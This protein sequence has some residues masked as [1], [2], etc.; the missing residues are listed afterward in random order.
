MAG[1]ITHC[2]L[3]FS[4][5]RPASFDDGANHSAAIE[6]RRLRPHLV[7][8]R[9]DHRHGDGAHSSAGRIEPVRDQ[10]HRSRHRLHRNH[11]GDIALCGA[12]GACSR[13][14]LFISRPSHGTSLPAAGQIKLE[15][16]RQCENTNLM[17]HVRSGCDAIEC[18]GVRWRH[19]C[20]LVRPR[21]G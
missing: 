15:S 11:L 19:R 17:E 12:D 18:T 21:S 5:R 6:S 8:R 2:A 16:P 20:R 9:Y 7:R 4:F 13:I 3:A 14:T 10:Q 1:G